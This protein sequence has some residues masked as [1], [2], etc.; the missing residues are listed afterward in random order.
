MKRSLPFIALALL[1]SVALPQSASAQFEHLN[2]DTFIKGLRER[3]MNELLEALAQS[4]AIKDD[5][6]KRILDIEQK[7]LRATQVPTL[8]PQE[9][10]QVM[11][12]AVDGF[13]KLIEAHRDKVNRGNWQADM[14]LHLLFTVPN[15]N[16]FAEDFYLYGIASPEQTQVY[17]DAA[18]KAYQALVDA[19]AHLWKMQNGLPRRDDFAEMFQ[20]T[21]RWE[22]LVDQYKRT[23]VPFL[24]AQAAYNVA[25]LPDT[26]PYFRNLGTNPR[27]PG[28]KL[29][30]PLERKR[31][32][33]QVLDSINSLDKQLKER[34][35]IAE[36]PLMLLSGKAQIGL[37]NYDEGIKLL[38][39]AYNKSP[40][41]LFAFRARLAKAD[42]LD[43]QL[44]AA[45]KQSNQP[46]LDTLTELEEHKL[47]KSDLLFRILITDLKHRL[48]M[49][50]V[51]NGEDR[52]EK[53]EVA[54][55]P[56]DDLV[57]DPRLGANLQ[58][59]R[60]FIYNRWKDRFTGTDKSD[61]PNMVLAGMAEIERINGQNVVAEAFR[62]G[63]A[64]DEA[65]KEARM[66]EAR[67][68]L[69][70]AI[71]LCDQLIERT[72]YLE[73]VIK[74]RDEAAAKAAE[75][76]AA[77]AQQQNQ[78]TGD[79]GDPNAGKA[80]GDMDEEFKFTPKQQIDL[81]VRARAYYNKAYAEYVSDP[82][83]LRNHISASA[84]WTRI[85]AEVPDHPLAVESIGLAIQLTHNLHIRFEADP[86]IQKAY[87]DVCDVL[88]S[89]MPESSAAMDERVYYTFNV[90]QKAAKYE[91]AS[92]SYA[93]VPPSHPSY[94]EAQREKLYCDFV[95]Y[96]DL[97]NKINDLQGKIEEIGDTNPAE[98]TKLK[99]EVEALEAKRAAGPRKLREQSIEL[100]RHIQQSIADATDDEQAAALRKSMGDVVLTRAD[101]EVETKQ[102]AEAE[103]RLNNLADDYDDP[104]LKQRARQKL[105]VVKVEQGDATKAVELAQ[106]MMDAAGSDAQ[107]QANVAATIDN[108]L[109][110]IARTV[111]ERRYQSLVVTGNERRKQLRA[112]AVTLAKAAQ[113]LA[114]MLIDWADKQNF[115]PDEMFTYRAIYV[116]SLIL[117]ESW[118][119]AEKAL[120]PLVDEFPEEPR[121]IYYQGE[122]LFNATNADGS[123]NRD[124]V[125]QS[126]YLYD[127]LTK[128]IKPEDGELQKEL[129][130]NA[131]LRRLQIHDKLNVHTD[132]IPD[133]IG[134][135]KFQYGDLGGPAMERRLRTLRLKYQK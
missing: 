69:G 65:T 84:S 48:L 102:W 81:A 63:G 57:S 118:T 96:K 11:N 58:H 59:V 135:L 67:T 10:A 60:V 95:L 85:A 134:Q 35:G 75:A 73:A 61:L 116:Q 37:G 112:S 99:K 72:N 91:E 41:D 28:Q 109:R 105:I 42:G 97:A 5:A 27:I 103:K 20:N 12:A 70:R 126:V 13:D 34:F 98:K 52:Q 133:L 2:L 14:A 47:A 21:G 15:L 51:G 54:Y 71:V 80:L 17:E 39:A 45:K 56:Y 31:L 25:Q 83:D 53:I 121:V 40:D 108:V 86:K 79:N 122:V 8:T 127:K 26:H 18:P 46:A 132:S 88:F 131:W 22:E 4:D 68:I 90:L 43:R 92:K 89:K 93:L 1:V 120:K 77:A 124:K 107:E 16:R 117:S 125:K 19:D 87:K 30:P 123:P 76:Q 44:T 74:K 66:E 3:G 100:E 24:L 128:A 104:A 113:T 36:R 130:W 94:V 114:K 82:E 111:E 49:R 129:W 101:L 9:K 110:E 32:Y 7:I 62:A 78:N 23:K 38:D 6:S 33:E 115:D 119:A 29:T 55:K 50:H 106:Q 64:G